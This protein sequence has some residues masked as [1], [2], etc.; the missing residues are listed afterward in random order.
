[1][2]HVNGHMILGALGAIETSLK[3]QDIPHGDGALAAASSVLA[4]PD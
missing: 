3:A 4:Q 1:M 2:G